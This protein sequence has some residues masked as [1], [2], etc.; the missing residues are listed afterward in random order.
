MMRNNVLLFSNI[1]RMMS[2]SFLLLMTLFLSGCDDEDTLSLSGKSIIYC[3]EGSPEN[4][5]PQTAISGTT[6][7]ATTNQIYNRLITFN[8]KNNSITPSLAK[9]W[10]VTR[11]GKMVTFYLR[12]DVEYH[13]T[14]YFTP[15]RTFNANDVIFSFKRILDTHHQYHYVS[16]GKYPFFEMVKFNALV[17]KVEK[18]NNYTVRFKLHHADSSFLANL[19]TDFAVILS[20]EYAQKLSEEYASQQID[21]LPIGTGPF[22]L[23]EYR[24]GSFIRYYRHESYWQGKAA[25]EQ[26]VFDITPSNTGRLTKL[27]TNECDIS[28]YPIAHENIIKRKELMLTSVI[29]LNTSYLGFNTQ[30]APFDNIQ[31]R[32]ALSYAI[33]KQAIINTVYFGQAEIANSLLPPTSWAFDDTIKNKSY[34]IEK[35]K[36]LLINAGYKNG[37]TINLWVMP[38][39]RTYGPN[40]LTIA[41]L[42]KA[43]LGKIAIKVNLITPETDEFLTDINQGKHQA[44]LLDW[45]ADH[46]DPD[47]FF[48]SLLSCNSK[49]SFSKSTSW[50]NNNFEKLLQKSLQTN[51]IN[52]RK[53]YYAQALAMIDDEVP[54]IP[55][56]HSKRSQAQHKKIEGDILH[57]FGG[58]N[59]TQVTKN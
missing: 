25:L 15:T 35:A 36:E 55:I 49:H 56:A 5:N 53:K 31:V 9:S 7:D 59:F 1:H 52:R 19:A 4:F 20:A 58:I 27:L 12:K 37:F 29:S 26:L 33:D 51:N 21:I 40:T 50:C 32:Q 23:K 47:N 41:K 24:V 34:S 2:T 16:G 39:Q 30:Q 18:I 48:T 6:I 14:D 8:E 57:S 3:A 54:L 11:D 42:I 10:H 45:T 44:V 46:P 28:A 13:T 43:E 22:K 38:I 17:D